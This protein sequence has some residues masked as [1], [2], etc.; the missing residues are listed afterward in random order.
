M[1]GKIDSTAAAGTQCGN[2]F[3]FAE[4][5]CIF[6]ANPLLSE[7][8]VSDPHLMHSLYHEWDRFATT[9]EKIVQNIQKI[10][11]KKVER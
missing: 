4:Q 10:V 1:L 9:I 6:Y 3:V 8:G 5:N 2:D 7:K 11:E